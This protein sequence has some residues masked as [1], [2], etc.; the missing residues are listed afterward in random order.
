M[1]YL[2]ISFPTHGSKRDV[3][4]ISRKTSHVR[5]NF[6]SE[7]AHIRLGY[8]GDQGSIFGAQEHRPCKTIIWHQGEK[9]LRVFPRPG[10]GGAWT[11]K[12]SHVEQTL[13]EY[14]C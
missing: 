6:D 10:E 14:Q 2:D 7:A 1:G 5:A 3:R 8:G 11:L 12:I 13:A 4:M 9:G